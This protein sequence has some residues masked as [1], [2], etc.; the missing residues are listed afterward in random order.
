MAWGEVPP[1][2]GFPRAFETSTLISARSTSK[3]FPN[4][5]VGSVGSLIVLG[6]FL[7][8]GLTSNVLGFFTSTETAAGSA[9]RR[10][11]RPLSLPRPWRIMM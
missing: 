10:S 2:D 5:R 4:I 1:G 9:G 6:M 8:A 7:A 3:T 11:S